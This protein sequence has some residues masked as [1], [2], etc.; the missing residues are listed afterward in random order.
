VD[1]EPPIASDVAAPEATVY[2]D[3]VVV[4]VARPGVV[5]PL[6]VAAL[7]VLEA[8]LLANSRSG[9]GVEDRHEILGPLEL[10]EVEHGG[11]A[12]VGRGRRPVPDIVV[13]G[14]HAEVVEGALLGRLGAR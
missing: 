1:I 13:D 9:D 3:E 14:D 11:P 8:N 10:G 7:G 6:P 2:V 5:G 4:P 12:P